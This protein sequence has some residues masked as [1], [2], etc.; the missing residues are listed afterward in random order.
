MPTPKK[1][2]LLVNLGTPDAPE[3]GPVGPGDA[4]RLAAAGT[5]DEPEADGSATDFR[6][7]GARILE[8]IRMKMGNIGGPRLPGGG[9]RGGRR[10]GARGAA[11]D[12]RPK[13]KLNPST[14]GKHMRELM[15]PRRR[16]LAAGIALV[17]VLTALTF[18]LFG[19][20][21]GLW[22]EGFEKLQIVPM[23]IIT[24]LTFLGGSFYSI[25]MLPP[26]WQKV[27]LFNPVVY[28]VSGFRW[29]F[30]GSSDVSVGVSLGMTTVF[31]VVCLVAIRWVFKTG[32]RLK[33]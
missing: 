1:G 19:F 5:D 29:S 15:W 24:P 12:D 23:L 8:E 18:C 4:E 28:L 6:A 30:Y 16:E 33:S 26:F 13:A 14:V 27:A 25:N 20:I 7:R 9:G 2:V 10:G 32:Y 17:L 21:I 31:M 11:G 3:A 22:A